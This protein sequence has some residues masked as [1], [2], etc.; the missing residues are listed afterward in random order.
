[1][2][3][4]CSRAPSRLPFQTHRRRVRR[5]IKQG[6]TAFRNACDSMRQKF[7]G[8]TVVPDHFFPD[9]TRSRRRGP[10]WSRASDRA[11]GTART[12]RSR[13]R[14]N[15][16]RSMQSHT[17]CPR[18]RGRMLASRLSI[19]TK[20]FV[21]A[22]SKMRPSRL[23]DC[24]HTRMHARQRWNIVRVGTARATRPSEAHPRQAHGLLDLITQRG[25]LGN[26]EAAR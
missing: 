26:F 4:L 22:R 6:K 12:H 2:G 3:E 24:V 23:A 21:P 7:G 1:M 25:S 18:G 14:H 20:T 13:A 11:S 8:S 16:G 19:P 17:R 15:G 5:I 10:L 9:E